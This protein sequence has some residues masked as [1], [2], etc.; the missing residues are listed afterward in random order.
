M[1]HPAHPGP[2]TTP[3][4]SA[5][6]EADVGDRTPPLTLVA[7]AAGPDIILAFDL[8]VISEKFSVKFFSFVFVPS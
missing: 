5:L 8:R 2:G 3:L 6:G 4:P 1:A 7:L